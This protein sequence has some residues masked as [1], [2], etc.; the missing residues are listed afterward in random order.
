MR[1]R[2]ALLACLVLACL[3]L[4]AG[5]AQAS[6]VAS[7]TV[8]ASGLQY[9]WDVL[10]L[11]DG[12]TLVTERPGRVRVIDAAGNLQA[13]PAYADPA[14]AKF[15]GLAKDPAYASN[16][17]VYLYVS[18]GSGAN[19][20]ANRVVRLTDTGTSLVSPVTIFN[21]GIQSD[22]NHD[23]GRIAFGPDGM[24]YVTTGDVHN[25]A[26][27]RDLNSLNGKIL[28]MTSSGAAPADNPYPGAGARAYVWTLGHRHPQGIGWD[29][30][31][32]MWESEHGPSGEAY[33][34]AGAK[35]GNDEINRID[36][37]ADYGWPTVAGDQTAP[38][39]RTP[40]AHAS[41][42]PAWAP[43]GLAFGPDRVMYAPFLAG[44]EL[45]AFT[46]S[47]DTITGQASL[48]DGTFGRMRAATADA[49]HLWLTTSNDTNNEK[50][51]RVPFDPASIPPTA[52]P[53]PVAGLSRAQLR[54]IVRGILGR[55]AK[56][57]R[58]KR[59]RKLA[60]V[61]KLRLTDA[62][63]PA[64]RLS[65]A[66]ER[67]GIKRKRARV[68]VLGGK[69]ATR[70]GR[71][72]A[73]TTKLSRKSRRLLRTAARRKGRLKLTLRVGLRTADKRLATGRR[74]ITILRR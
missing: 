28:R 52:T 67:P 2:A 32:R 18:Y 1:T 54:A 30:Q 12:R 15:L 63:L 59:A 37:G 49:T 21:G 74:T 36:K 57:L 71:R 53:A 70:A 68:Q 50:V 17:F 14:A 16:R 24:L 38:G 51:V 5:P 27:P 48:F 7:P 43:G 73:V 42:S 62:V 8:V 58:S 65:I 20:N 66:V 31:G 25:P 22:G 39:V 23:G 56:A 35:T 9:P 3:G 29:F 33:A 47:G 26:L 64:G 60:K 6:L 34:P 41:S 19:P 55:Q 61:S 40:V 46:T 11:P 13:A 45:R 44:T 4:G 10:R 72:A 69:A